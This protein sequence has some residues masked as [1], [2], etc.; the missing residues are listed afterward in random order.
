MDA[1]F[2][3][4]VHLRSLDERNGHLLLRFFSFLEAAPGRP[5]IFLLG[6]IFDVW[7]GNHRVFKKRF[8]ALL[9]VIDRL[10]T[11]GCRIIYF[12]GNHDLHLKKFWQDKLGAEVFT[13]AATF[14]V[15]GMTIRCEHGDEMNL[16]DLA[17]LRLRRFLRHPVTEKALLNM[18]GALLDFLAN[19]WSQHSRGQSSRDEKSEAIRKTIRTHAERVARQENFDVIVSGHMHVRD[20][21]SFDFEGRGVRSINLGTWLTEPKALILDNGRLEWRD[22]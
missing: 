14:Q 12:E 5:T 6:D 15:G 7:V 4:D 3:S 17:Y 18:P 9:E 19:K 16:E 22:P 20:D 1:A 21:W 8:G 10:R 13:E 11:R 2:I